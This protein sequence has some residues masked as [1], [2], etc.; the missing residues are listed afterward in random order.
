MVSVYK[1]W[2]VWGANYG[3]Q[4]Q[5]L[6]REIFFFFFLSENVSYKR[7][8]F[9]E[10]QENAC[11]IL[12]TVSHQLF[13]L[14]HFDWT[15]LKATTPKLSIHPVMDGGVEQTGQMGQRLN[16]YSTFKEKKLACQIVF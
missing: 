14:Y 10:L 7:Q 15:L 8:I 1:G 3:G 13:L 6:Y 4:A 5:L 11:S 9:Q 2:R 12:S 16:V